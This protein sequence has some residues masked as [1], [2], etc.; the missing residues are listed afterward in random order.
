M[1]ILDADFR[2]RSLAAFVGTMVCEAPLAC[3]L[4]D[5]MAQ[6]FHRWRGRSGTKYTATVYSIDHDDPLA[7][8][9]NLGPAILMAVARNGAARDIVGLVAIERDSD[10]SH[11]VQRLQAGANEWHVHLLAPD[12]ATRAAVLADLGTSQR[13]AVVA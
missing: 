9:P 2:V 12:R 10:W 1:Q 8:L 6:R 11:A 4:E 5:A 3:L 7:A 13:M